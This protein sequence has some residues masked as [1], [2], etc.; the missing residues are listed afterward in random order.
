MPL[1]SLTMTDDTALTPVEAARIY[2]ANG[3]SCIPVP[4]KS[5]IPI[6]KV[7]GKLRLTEAECAATF[8][9]DA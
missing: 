6:L 4:F 3:W 8:N 7:W 1:G 5:K 9:G 2:A